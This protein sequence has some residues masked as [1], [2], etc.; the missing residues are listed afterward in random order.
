MLSSVQW[1]NR[2]SKS[3]PSCWKPKFLS[4]KFHPLILLCLILL[5]V[6]QLKKK[7]HLALLTMETRS[8]LAEDNTLSSWLPLSTQDCM[9]VTSES[10]RPSQLRKAWR[11]ASLPEL[12]FLLVRRVNRLQL[13]NN[14]FSFFFFYIFLISLARP[15]EL[16]C[17]HRVL[18]ESNLNCL[19]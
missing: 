8:R 12:R 9:C 3:S 15:S 4:V 2:S 11:F 5:A 6:Y 17:S 10:I 7:N 1:L 18:N 19:A 16:T 13:H 14:N